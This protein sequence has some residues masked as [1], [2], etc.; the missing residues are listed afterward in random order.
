MRFKLI[1]DYLHNYYNPVDVTEAN[2]LNINLGDNYPNITIDNT[3][4]SS[5]STT[6]RLT[7]SAT[8][9]NIRGITEILNELIDGE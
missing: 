8:G 2:P 5:P 4:I 6:P 7:T 3:H 9:S 1:Y